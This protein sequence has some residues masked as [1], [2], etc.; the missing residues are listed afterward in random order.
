MYKTKIDDNFHNYLVKGASLEG[1]AGIPMLMPTKN[2]E[3]PKGLI[4]Y[5]KARKG[6]YKERYVHFYLFDKYFNSILTAT[7]KYID[8]LKS[9]AGVITP[10]FSILI[11]QA[12]CLQETNTYFSRAVGFYLQK[13]GILIIPNVRW[14]D[15]TTYSFCF[16]G[17]P[18]NSV[19]AISTHGC[20]RNKELREIYKAGL[21]KML[22]V[23]EPTDVIVYGSKADD[24]FSKYD[25]HVK[26][27]FYPSWT[28][29]MLKPKGGD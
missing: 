5:D 19:V 26:F 22:K 1:E 13:Q 2:S 7:N 28:S 27:H 17:I 10:D 11:N 6:I 14:G 25:K 16:L 24:I 18:K 3:I 21:Y 4:P 23:L 20:I 8:L 9:Y 29:E 12:K 15:K